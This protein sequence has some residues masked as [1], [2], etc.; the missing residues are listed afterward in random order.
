MFFDE[1]GILDLDNM[2]VN[3]PSFKK[4]MDDGIVTEEEIKTQSE[5]VIT[6]LHEM[7]NR[8]TPDQ[9]LEIRDLLVESSVLYAVYNIHN[10][11]NL[12]Q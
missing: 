2:I 12:N 6:L 10:I 11:Q 8:Y 5:K 7:E 3:N 1:K 9:L 4:I